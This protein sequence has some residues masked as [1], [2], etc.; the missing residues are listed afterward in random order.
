MSE[1]ALHDMLLSDAAGRILQADRIARRL[2]ASVWLLALVITLTSICFAW[3]DKS[4]GAFGIA[5]AVA[6]VANLVL[7]VGSLIVLVVLKHKHPELRHIRHPQQAAVF[8][9]ILS[10]AVVFFA[11]FSMPLHG[12]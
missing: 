1:P 5:V 2:T 8:V 3:M 7:L 11:I 12:C 9:P 10:A 6:P 4:W